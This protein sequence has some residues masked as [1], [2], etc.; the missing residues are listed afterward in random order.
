MK[1]SLIEETPMDHPSPHRVGP[2]SH[3]LRWLL[4][5]GLAGFFVAD[6]PTYRAA[7]TDQMP[8][9]IPKAPRYLAGFP[10]PFPRPV[11]Y[12][13]RQGSVVVADLD[14]NGGQELIVSIP[15][16]QV[17]VLRSDGSRVPGW[18][19][20]FDDLA[21]P[22]VPVGEPAIGDLDGDGSPDIVT[23][24]VSGALSRRNFLYAMRK[25]GSDLPGWPIELRDTSPDYYSCSNIPTLLADL[26]GDGAQEVVRG[27]NRGI[28]LGFDRSGK[29]LPRWPVRLGQDSQGRIREINADMAVADLNGDGR[30][31][32]VFVESAIAPRLAVVSFDGRFLPGFPMS[33][34]EMVD[35]QAPAVADLDGDGRPE[36]VQ[37][38][39]PYAGD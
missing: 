11:D 5:L 15:S 21:Q 36:L 12:R 35:R 24:I 26:N 27:M 4:L 10:I 16:G 31:D 33:L 22:I 19:R 17:L 23:C 18:P 38:T 7:Q 2:R 20:T 8:G 34:S 13:P 1:L 30:D 3:A 39:M 25:D 14:R 9:S 29:P 6:G 28:I 32:L 37:G